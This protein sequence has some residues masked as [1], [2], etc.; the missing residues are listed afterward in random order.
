MKILV[1]FPINTQVVLRNEIKIVFSN[2]FSSQRP[3]P[4][5]R[6][7]S[8]VPD[9]ICVSL[10]VGS[11]TETK[12]VLMELTRVSKLA[13]VSDGWELQKYMD[14]RLN[15]YDTYRSFYL[16]HLSFF[17]FFVSQCSTTHAAATSS[18]ART[19]SVSPNTLCVTTTPTAAMPR[20]SPRSVVSGAVASYS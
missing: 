15:P 10:S 3:K 18:C 1:F 16:I 2:L 14:K 8:S 20:T 12:T 6:R 11:V 4:A 13:A 9:H 7:R 5:V 19:D 17:F